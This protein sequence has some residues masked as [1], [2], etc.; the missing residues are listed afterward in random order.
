MES[1]EQEGGGGGRDRLRSLSF[2]E[3]CYV[4]FLFISFS[5]VADSTKTTAQN[6]TNTS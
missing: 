2:R 6:G 3:L 5:P 1:R 4:S